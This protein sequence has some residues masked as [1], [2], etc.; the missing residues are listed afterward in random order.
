MPRKKFNKT[1]PLAAAGK[2]LAALLSR[3]YAGKI[4]L[5]A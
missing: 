5:E 3:R 4:V 2:A 1:F